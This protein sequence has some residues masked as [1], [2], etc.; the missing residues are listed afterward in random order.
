[1]I[2]EPFKKLDCDVT[3]NK[4]IKTIPNARINFLDV[5]CVFGIIYSI[6]MQSGEQHVLKHLLQVNSKECP[7]V[8]QSHLIAFMYANRV[9]NIY[10]LHLHVLT[11]P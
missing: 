6:D 2:R 5:I 7:L 9:T 4:A 3:F 8:H 10:S 11:V 1:M